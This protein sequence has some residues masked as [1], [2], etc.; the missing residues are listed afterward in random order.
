[1]KKAP[2]FFVLLA[3]VSLYSSC[4][5]TL[6]KLERSNDY[7]E[8]YNGA[9]AYYERGKYDRAKL[10]FERI[11]PYYRG[12]EQAE[13]IRYY[14]AYSEY[15]MGLY[16][17]AAYQ[18]KEFYQTF[19]R[20]PLAE[21]A[22]YMEAYSLYLDSPDA[23]LDQNSSEQAVIAMQNFLNRYPA[24]QRYQE[25]NRIIDELQ[26]RFETKAYQTAKL[27]YKLTTG[28]SYR[29]YLEAALVTFEA[30]KEDFP[31]SKYNEELL[32]LSVETSFKLA[33]NSITTKRKERF[34]KTIELY[35]EFTEKYP[36]SQYTNR[37]KDYYE[38]SIKELNKLKT[39]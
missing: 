35:R 31:D 20:S 10:L 19:G 22:Q 32:Y 29:N 5:T 16:Q 28:L 27:Y 14:W 4:T 26:V 30:F 13:K 9:I 2:F 36:E 21:E 25:A 18:F 15:Y 33:D 6:G 24:S 12:S 11:Y 7:N 34:D 37:V 3:I 1:M 38:Q 39:D 17:L 8:L 23:E